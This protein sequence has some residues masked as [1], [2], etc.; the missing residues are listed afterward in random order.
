MFGINGF[1]YSEQLVK[2]YELAIFLN[3]DYDQEKLVI[4]TLSQNNA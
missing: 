3:H 2:N 1:Q 4:S